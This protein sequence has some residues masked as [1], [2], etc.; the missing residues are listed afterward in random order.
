M[1]FAGYFLNQVFT[2]PGMLFVQKANQQAATPELPFT[3]PS[4]WPAQ[5]SKLHAHFLIFRSCKK[6]IFITF[7]LVRLLLLFDASF[8]SVLVVVVVIVL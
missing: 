4:H 1:S 2:P 7:P 5:A 3:S 8:V 6:H